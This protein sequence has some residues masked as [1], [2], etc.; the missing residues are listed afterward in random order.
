[1]ESKLFTELTATEQENLSG[2]QLLA[3]LGLNVA[4]PTAVSTN[5]FSAGASSAQNNVFQSNKLFSF[6]RG[7]DVQS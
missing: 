2:G 6:I 7:G 5:L 4:I 1:M 3:Q